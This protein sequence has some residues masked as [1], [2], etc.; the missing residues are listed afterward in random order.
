MLVVLGACCFGVSDIG[1]SNRLG[2]DA[3]C[4]SSEAEFEVGDM[5][6]LRFIAAEVPPCL[7][8]HLHSN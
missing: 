7:E 3:G 6:P 2:S 8:L 1:E 5:N 4:S